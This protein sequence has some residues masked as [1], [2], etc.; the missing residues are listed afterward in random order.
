M[1]GIGFEKDGGRILQAYEQAK[2]ERTNFESH[3][4]RV[5]DLVLPT[6]QFTSKLVPG[7]EIRAD[8]YDSTAQDAAETLA[9]SIHGMLT[10]QSIHW[11]NL[12]L[13]D[14]RLNEDYE[15]NMWLQDTRNRMLSVFASPKFQ[16]NT[17]A[18][19]I[20]LDMV[21]FGT[22]SLMLRDDVFGN[23]MFSSRPLSE[24]YLLGDENDMPTIRFRDV[25]LEPVRALQKFGASA[26]D[27]EV[28]RMAADD[29]NTRKVQFVHLIMN[30]SERD[31][32][33]MDGPNRP[34]ASV[35]VEAK[36]GKIVWEGGFNDEPYLNPRWSKAPGEVYGRSPAMRALP[37]I[38]MTQAMARSMI[39]ASELAVAPPLQV[40]A[41]SIEGP[42]NTEPN[43]IIYFRSGSQERITPLNSG[44]NLPL[45]MDFLEANREV[46]RRHFHLHL[47]TLPENDRMTAFEVSQR[48]QLRMQVLAPVL[49]RITGEFLGPLVQRVADTMSRNNQLLPAPEALR[50]SRLKVE[51][52][53][54]LALSQRASELGNINQLM[55]MI[56]PMAQ[57][58]PGV[59]DILDT[60][61]IARYGSTIMN[62]PAR[63]LRTRTEID[64]IRESRAQTQAALEQAQIQRE[65]AAAAK[66]QADALSSVAG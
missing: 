16:F 31:P 56:G 63:L 65:R 8:I 19:E 17:Q 59:M 66:D 53:G 57:V 9:S 24:L 39:M 32:E 48:Q 27:S 45:G 28:A 64:T 46:I 15:V 22:G 21:A 42:V 43:S 23:L 51:Y 20:Y 35:Y 18:H 12:A 62:V 11:F 36:T 41:D 5:A 13:E 60:D 58:D 2:S 40:P 25:W 10:N 14:D 3:W 7:A 26:L 61:E 33:R 52:V 4:Q 44:V 30:R 29:R 55:S 1:P 34:I 50:G 47:L 37:D 49:A 6:R 54:P 38:A